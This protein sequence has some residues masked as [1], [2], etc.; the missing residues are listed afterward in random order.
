MKSKHIKRFTLML[1]LLAAGGLAACS[2]SEETARPATISPYV[3]LVHLPGARVD[4]VAAALV[5]SIQDTDERTLGLPDDWTVVGAAVIPEH[6][7]LGATL[8]LPGGHRTVELCN[9]TYASMALSAGAH[10]AVGLPCKLS[11]LQREDGVEVVMLS[12]ESIFALFFHDVEPAMAA[13]MEGLAATVRE[14]IRSLVVRGVQGFEGAAWRNAPVGPGW[15]EDQ[16]AGF[17]DMASTV[18]YTVSPTTTEG[19]YASAAALRDAVA[20]RLLET[21][22]HEGSEQ[23]GC[24]VPGL[25]VDDWRSARTLALTLPGDVRLVEVCSP[26]YAAAAL[27]TGLH[28]APAL[29][30]KIAIHV[31]GD[32][33]HIEMLDTAFVFPSFFSDIPA[34][35]AE[36][37]HGM[38]TAVRTDIMRIIETVVDGL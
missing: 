26:T 25:S 3:S 34:E 36:A 32:V 33:V 15:T 35:H 30:C 6:G 18:R 1:F 16:L 7:A 20:D 22:T 2:T 19:T 24:T 12:P 8:K 28:H 37:L 17:G 21:L 23:V 10:R 38:A 13:Q 11:L 9:H 27:G 29:P 14:E 31:E 5:G 4:D